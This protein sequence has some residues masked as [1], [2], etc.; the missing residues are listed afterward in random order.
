MAAK[1]RAL[2]VSLPPE[3]LDRLRD[4]SA[5]VCGAITLNRLVA[6]AVELGLPAVEAKLAAAGKGNNGVSCHVSEGA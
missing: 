4:L 2:C 1:K 5:A 6:L 3:I